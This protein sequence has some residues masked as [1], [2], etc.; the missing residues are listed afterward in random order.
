MPEQV[1]RAWLRVF[2]PLPGDRRRCYISC[3]QHLSG[4]MA[5]PIPRDH[6]VPGYML[7]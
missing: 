4:E 3:A 7:V 1:S 2:L 5:A 6:P